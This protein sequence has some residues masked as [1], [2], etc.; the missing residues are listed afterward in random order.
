MLTVTSIK[1]MKYVVLIELNNIVFPIK[2]GSIFQSSPHEERAIRTSNL[3][4]KS[5][6]ELPL[7]PQQENE[8]NSWSW[9]FSWT[10]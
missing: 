5:S 9:V 1:L 3:R 7:V 10:K 8:P 2:I 6:N 4:G